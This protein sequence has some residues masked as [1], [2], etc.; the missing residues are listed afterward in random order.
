LTFQ[1]AIRTSATLRSL[2]VR[3]TV[4]SDYCCP[5]CYLALDRLDLLVD[6]G[7]E[8]DVL[9]FEL[10]PEI[11]PAGHRHR[12]GGRTSAAFARVAAEC[13]AAGLRFD[14]P[15]VTPNTAMVLGVAEAVRRTDPVAF[16]TLHRRLF[17]A[18]F[19]EGADLGDPEVVD[20]LVAEAGADPATP[21]AWRADG[22]GEAAVA[23]ARVE[24]V[25]VGVTATP[26]FRF[27][28]GLFV[29]GV[30][31]RETLERWVTR[32]RSRA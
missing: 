11:P 14:P 31:P 26:A 19:A 32:M 10:H 24:A 7:V 20:A 13:A 17:V 3:A 9:P 1:V 30:H 29:T 8:V 16:P 15:D 21:R 25:E 6:L 5:W 4:W 28:T 12:P 22:R 18:R 2:A 23:E 27:D